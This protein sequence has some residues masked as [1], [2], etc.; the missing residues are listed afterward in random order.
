MIDW[1]ICVY[2]VS[3]I[4]QLYNDGEVLRQN[5]MGEWYGG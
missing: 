1:L 3:A 4:L 5:K 2:A